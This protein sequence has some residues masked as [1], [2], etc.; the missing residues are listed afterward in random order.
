MKLPLCWAWEEDDGDIV[1]LKR[2]TLQPGQG[3]SS[4]WRHVGTLRDTPSCHPRAG[5]VCPL[6]FTNATAGA[7][8]QQVTLGPEQEATYP[9]LLV[10]LNFP[11]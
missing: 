10:R 11:L 5:Q 1:I 9:A 6:E 8:G 2:L 3:L 7:P 4:D